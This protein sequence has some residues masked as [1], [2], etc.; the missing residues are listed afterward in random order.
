[1]RDAAA[2]TGVSIDTIKRRLRAGAFP[3]ATRGPAVGERTAPWLI[4]AGDLIGA[5][6]PAQ[7]VENQAVLGSAE[8]RL[9]VQ[10]AVIAAQHAHLQDLRTELT[11]LTT[12]L[13][14]SL[15]ARD[16]ET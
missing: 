4:P 16:E 3:N 1:M 13:T 11:R 5:S 9:A 15:A 10:E 7:M 8:T 12:L 14:H 2:L 6:L